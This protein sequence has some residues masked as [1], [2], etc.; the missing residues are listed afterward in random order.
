MKHILPY[1]FKSKKNNMLLDK[2]IIG[3]YLLFCFS[4]FS[5]YNKYYQQKS[6]SLV[7][8]G[9]ENYREDQWT[10]E[11][12]LEQLTNA[13]YEAWSEWTKTSI[14]FTVAKQKLQKYTCP[15]NFTMGVLALWDK[16]ENALNFIS[17]NG[18]IKESYAIAIPQTWKNWNGYYLDA[19][20]NFD[21]SLTK[22][23]VPEGA[24]VWS[25]IFQKWVPWNSLFETKVLCIQEVSE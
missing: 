4:L 21:G 13:V 17:K 12:E 1:H 23:I 10:G 18:Y 8:L 2:Q 9:K 6:E 20:I 7:K 15:K 5:M 25:N 11:K 14:A 24:L 16:S 19:V 22:A 3:N